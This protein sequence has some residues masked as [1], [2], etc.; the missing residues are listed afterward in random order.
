MSVPLAMQTQ[1]NQEIPA[2]WKERDVATDSK[3]KGEKVR[4]STRE[5]D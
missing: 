3:H 5:K 1:G 4:Q 2:A